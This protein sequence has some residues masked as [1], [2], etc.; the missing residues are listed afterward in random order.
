MEIPNDEYVL[1]MI[2]GTEFSGEVIEL[3][4][5]CE[6]NL[7]ISE[8]VAVLLC[9]FVLKFFFSRLR[10]KTFNWMNELIDFR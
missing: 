1:P 2:P 3:G 10:S 9:M 7:E 5:D 8:K 4:P 6:S